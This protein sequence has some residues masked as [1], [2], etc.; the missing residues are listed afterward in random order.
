MTL[1]EYLSTLSTKELMEIHRRMGRDVRELILHDLEGF[2]KKQ[3]V[4]E[5][6]AMG[7]DVE[8]IELSP[9]KKT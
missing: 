4:Y 3:V 9:S 7:Y 8:E 5:L 2:R 1:R 6:R